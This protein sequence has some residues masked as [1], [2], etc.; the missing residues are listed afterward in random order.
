MT[1]WGALRLRMSLPIHFAPFQAHSWGV[2]LGAGPPCSLYEKFLGD[3]FVA[4]KV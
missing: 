4:V 3:I 1:C 2:I